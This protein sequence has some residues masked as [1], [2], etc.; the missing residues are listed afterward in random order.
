MWTIDDVKALGDVGVI[1]ALDAADAKVASAK[2]RARNARA[3]MRRKLTKRLSRI[4]ADIESDSPP[5]VMIQ[6]RKVALRM[7]SAIDIDQDDDTED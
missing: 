3:T 7:A 6:V 1:A 4:I 5:D 2:D